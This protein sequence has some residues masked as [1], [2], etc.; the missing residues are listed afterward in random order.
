MMP[1]LLLDCQVDFGVS[2]ESLTLKFPPGKNFKD[3]KRR[4]FIITSAVPLAFVF[5]A[6]FCFSA[7][8]TIPGPFGSYQVTIP[9]SPKG[10]KENLEFFNAIRPSLPDPVSIFTAPLPTGSGARALGLAGAFTAIADDATAASWNPGGLIQLERP[11][12][13]IVGMFSFDRQELSAES[14]DFELYDSS[15][16]AQD[17][18]YVSAVLPFRFLERNFVISLNYQQVFDFSQEFDLSKSEATE[19]GVS[20]F[21]QE[22][23]SQTLTRY[24]NDGI[25]SAQILIDLD[26]VTQ[27]LT[28]GTTS[29]STSQDVAFEQD[30]ALYA[31]S[32]A[33]AFEI[34]PRLAL[35]AAFNFFG[36]DPF[37]KRTF[38]STT[39]SSYSG[40][41]SFSGTIYTFSGTDGSY[42]Y[43]GTITDPESG[44][45]TPISGE[46]DYDP[47]Q[48]ESNENYSS[49]LSFKG[50]FLRE[51]EFTNAYGFNSTIGFLWNISSKISLGGTVDLP[52]ELEGDQKTTTVS[53]I[54]IWDS[55][56]GEQ[57][58]DSE[59]EVE[60]KETITYYFPLY[61]AFG[62]AYRWSDAFT[63]ALDVSQT[64]WSDYKYKLEDGTKL[65]PLNGKPYGENK[66]GDTW[67]V[68]LGSEYL[69]IT[70]KTEIPLRGGV[71]WEQ[72][73][74]LGSPD[75]YFGFSLG[76]GFSLGKDPGK[77]ILDIAYIFKYGSNVLG[78]VFPSET[79]VSADIIEHKIL[80]SLIW[81]F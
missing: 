80:T 66:V 43:A 32:P 67:T 40:T 51:N 46:G 71:F 17:L 37:S 5:V 44:I 14:D 23:Y 16:E 3:M 18:N 35:G 29:Y 49:Q 25:T 52:Y 58:D 55:D 26:T 34:T 13:S 19:E 1:Q 22:N 77:L 41:S 54:T 48:Q 10:P 60:S 27:T 42:S 64:L 21:Q 65:N 30:G 11:E 81:H 47:I 76:S 7:V 56:T 20:L 45:T 63:T 9:D 38:K 59:E 62:C 73:P 4:R 15:F 8:I 24:Y 28:Q 36:D 12:I 57:L 33:L 2:S 68:R 39:R 75:D 74:A 61:W 50:E 6:P 79:G 53:E 69:F 70:E 31:F 72:R 78:D